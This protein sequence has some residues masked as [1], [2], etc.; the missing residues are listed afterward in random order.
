MLLAFGGTRTYHRLTCAIEDAGWEIRDCISYFS[1]GTQQERAFLESLDEEQLA[2]YLELHYPAGQMSWVYGQGMGLGLNV[3]KAIDKAA[4]AERE[5]VGPNPYSSSGRKPGVMH[6]AGGNHRPQMEAKMRELGIDKPPITAPSAPLAKTF[7]GWNSRLKP[8][9]EPIVVA[10]KPLD[11]TYAENA[12][13]WRVAGLNIDEGRVGTGDNLNGG[14]YSG[15]SGNRN[16]SSYIMG[17]QAKNYTQPKGRFP[18]NLLQS[19]EPG[20]LREFG[21]AGVRVSNGG[22]GPHRIQATQA[23]NDNRTA[24]GDYGASKD[25]VFGDSGSASRYFAQCPP[26]TEPARLTYHAKASTRERGN[27]NNHP[28]VKP[29]SLLRYLC[30]L[31]RTPYGGL[32]LD[33]FGGSGTTGIACISEK[34]DFILI[35]KEP[36]YVGIA[37][38]RIAEYTG[39]TIEAKEIKIKEDTVKQMALW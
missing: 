32:V 2:A 39:E 25:F 20:V 12:E 10:M 31:T 36:D 15:E 7:D 13:R 35:E 19:N 16:G 38:R 34:R 8:A 33:P 26:D 23:R 29:L 14:A 1:D 6:V 18:S 24:Y 11:G 30:R 9:V 21:K 28:T 22:R 3:S 4:G 5:I 27:G 17:Q 37:R